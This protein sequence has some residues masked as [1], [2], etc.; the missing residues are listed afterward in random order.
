[1]CGGSRGYHARVRHGPPRARRRPAATLVEAI[2]VVALGL[3]ILG[4][5]I[6][7]ARFL[8]TRTATGAEEAARAR[9]LSLFMEQLRRILRYRA[10]RVL[11]VPG[12]FRVIHTRG[13]LVAGGVW[14]LEWSEFRAEEGATGTVLILQE[15]GHERRYEIADRSVTLELSGQD[16]ELIRVLIDGLPQQ[17]GY[18][19]RIQPLQRA[20]R[21]LLGHPALVGGGGAGGV[22]ASGGG[23]DGTGPGDG[24]GTGDGS[25][26]GEGPGGPGGA[27][28]GG[29]LP[30]TGAGR[31]GDDEGA[32][33]RPLASDLSMEALY[34]QIREEEQGGWTA[35]A[36]VP[37]QGEARLLASQSPEVGPAEGDEEEAFV[38]LGSGPVDG[39]LE[40][41]ADVA[42]LEMSDL[43]RPFLPRGPLPPGSPGL[44]DPTALRARLG[45]GGYGPAQADVMGTMVT[46]WE[47]GV[48]DG[49]RRA[50]AEALRGLQAIMVADGQGDAEVAAML[51]G[52]SEIG[53]VLGTGGLGT[54]PADADPPPDG[55]EPVEE[56]LD[57]P[58]TL[59]TGGVDPAP[60]AALPGEWLGGGAGPP[61][62]PG[63]PGT[64]GGT[65]PAGQCEADCQARGYDADHCQ[66]FCQVAAQLGISPGL[67]GC[68][69]GCRS[70][71]YPASEC[72]DYCG[73]DT[74]GAGGSA[75]PVAQCINDCIQAGGDPTGC[76]FQCGGT[77]G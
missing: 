16:P 38:P 15:G 1:M 47:Q 33:L 75:P 63:N 52:V 61:G 35:A 7:A 14:G 60:V 6:T 25:G 40:T 70:L 9:D 5:V 17:T 24:S 58:Q 12:G 21:P 54:M 36:A 53:F 55:Q 13:D 8:G 30:G 39:S 71:G 19:A 41:E 73:P 31:G 11:P 69:S 10:V 65:A 76:S 42:A 34:E 56:P 67:P 20:L 59:D 32:W 27:P 77:G 46:A 3:G 72:N 68:N 28:G 4:F 18:Q 66:T 57:S 62:S 45:D 48:L 29:G 43:G 51:S 37:P 50:A 23:G 44:S 64:P 49:D 26:G 74:A 22:G 2:L